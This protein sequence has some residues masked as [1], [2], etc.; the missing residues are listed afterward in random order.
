MHKELE[1]KTDLWQQR[2]IRK[3]NPIYIHLKIFLF[4]LEKV[5]TG[6]KMGVIKV[7]ADISAERLVMKVFWC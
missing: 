3:K 6:S 2:S 7:Q 1:E 5:E 4:F